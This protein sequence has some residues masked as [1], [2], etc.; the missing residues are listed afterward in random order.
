[1]KPNIRVILEHCVEV[2]LEHGYNRAHKHTDAPTRAVMLEEMERAVWLK[3]DTY[4]K[5]ENEE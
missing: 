1:M 4:F 2:G 3:I 5:F